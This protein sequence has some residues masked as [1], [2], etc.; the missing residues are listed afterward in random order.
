MDEQVEHLVEDYYFLHM[1]ELDI[2]YHSTGDCYF[3]TI[4]ET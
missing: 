4:I 3:T 2:H 1:L